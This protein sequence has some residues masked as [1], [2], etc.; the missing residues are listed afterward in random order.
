MFGSENMKI[1]KG[2]SKQSSYTEGQ[3]LCVVE[4]IRVHLLSASAL[5]SHLY[6]FLA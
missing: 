6:F 4:N 3:N 5:G 2:N 1:Y